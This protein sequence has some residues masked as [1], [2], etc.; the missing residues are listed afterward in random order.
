MNRGRYRDGEIH[1]LISQTEVKNSAE[2]SR[3][4]GFHRER[5]SQ[6]CR[7]D[8]YPSDD[9]FKRLSEALGVDEGKVRLAAAKDFMCGNLVTRAERDLEVQ[10]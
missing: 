2:L 9:M 7:G 1:A 4:M 10:G 3:R 8:A 6:F 5:I